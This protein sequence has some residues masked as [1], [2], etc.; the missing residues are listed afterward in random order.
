ML[1]GANR[2]KKKKDFERVFKTGQT[3]KEGFL[4]LKLIKNHLKIS[5]FGFVVSQKISK[6]AT[7]RNKIKRRLREIIKGKLAGTKKGWDAVLVVR[8]GLEN[9]DFWEM[10]E[11]I[12][13]LF[14]KAKIIKSE[15]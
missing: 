8:P 15:T 5:R 3:F 6:R 2:L 1:P 11:A 7:I 10:E 4:I 14:K 9:K 13:K 12:N